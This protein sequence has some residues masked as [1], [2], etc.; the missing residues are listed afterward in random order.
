MCGIL[1]GA[2]A[3]YR[4]YLNRE[5]PY[6]Q[7]RKNIVGEL[8]SDVGGSV[9]GYNII[10][11]LEREALQYASNG[12]FS[13]EAVIKQNALSSIDRAIY[14]IQQID[15]AKTALSAILDKNLTIPL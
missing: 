9:T 6:T 10:S 11:S 1:I 13:T 3:V 7:E 4:S 14:Q 12:V 5:F 15:P 2:Y 8:L